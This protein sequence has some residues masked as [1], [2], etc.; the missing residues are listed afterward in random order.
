M[1]SSLFILEKANTL[2]NETIH[3]TFEFTMPLHGHQNKM[4]P[5]MKPFILVDFS[6][7]T[8]FPNYTCWST[9]DTQ[10]HLFSCQINN[11]HNGNKTLV[12]TNHVKIDS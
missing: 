11:H 7:G 4:V 2:P 8:K 9:S 6:N 10:S 12:L 3:I 5:L 1:T